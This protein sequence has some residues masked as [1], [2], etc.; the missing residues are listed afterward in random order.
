MPGNACL[1]FITLLSSFQSPDLVRQP[2]PGTWPQPEAKGGLHRGPFLQKAA[3][4][5]RH[6]NGPA[7]PH[8]CVPSQR[9]T[10]NSMWPNI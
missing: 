10:A 2:P 7:Q 4:P 9:S 6:G 3:V 5:T 8:P 1:C